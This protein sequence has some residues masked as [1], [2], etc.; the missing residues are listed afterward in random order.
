MINKIENVFQR[1]ILNN[2]PTHFATSSKN[3]WKEEIH[4]GGARLKSNS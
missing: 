2:E 1:K 3:L 4:Q